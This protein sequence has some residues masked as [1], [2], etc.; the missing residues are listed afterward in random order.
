MGSMELNA[1]G[2]SL[3][4]KLIKSSLHLPFLKES[5][6]VSS[7]WLC[8][9]LFEG[10]SCFLSERHYVCSKLSALRLCGMPLTASWLWDCSLLTQV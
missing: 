9:V 3:D 6:K 5:G 8:G 4:K 2:G 10:L 7:L 1:S